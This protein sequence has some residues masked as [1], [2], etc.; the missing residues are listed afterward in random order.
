MKNRLLQFSLIILTASIFVS[1]SKD[2]SE[3]VQAQVEVTGKWNI[4]SAESNFKSSSDE[5][6]NSVLDLRDQNLFIEFNADGTY[7]S[8]AEFGIGELNVNPNGI[9]SNTY[10]YNNGRL[11]IQLIESTL[12]KSVIL[13]FHPEGDDNNLVL[14]SGLDDLLD[15]YNDQVASFDLV[16]GFLI[17]ATIKSYTSLDFN[18]SLSK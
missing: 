17:D 8:N 16:T 6:T 15:A 5:E 18:I 11:D 4:S 12:D 14:K 10:S 3:D 9:V 1:C 2:D 13:Y 7:T